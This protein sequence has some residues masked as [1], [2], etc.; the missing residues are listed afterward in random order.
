MTDFQEI[1]YQAKHDPELQNTINIEEILRNSTVTKINNSTTNCEGG[2][3]ATVSV[4]SNISNN[5]VSALQS[6]PLP[7]DLIPDYCE[8][9]LDYQY[10]EE[11]H[12]LVIGKYIRWIRIENDPLYKLNIGGMITDIL[13]EDCAVFLKVKMLR[14]QYSCKLKY[15]NF[16]I[17]QKLTNDD[18][19]RLTVVDLLDS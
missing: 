6:I 14:A 10:I 11:V 5:V 7:P 3:K 4:W 15:D 12:E 16:I 8:R 17:F 18:K 2:R 9:L 19:I 1:L 13:I